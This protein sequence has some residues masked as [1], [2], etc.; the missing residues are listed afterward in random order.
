MSYDI[1][2][3]APGVTCPSCGRPADE[4]D[5][6]KPTYNLS[7]IFAKA[8]T[9]E[10]CVALRGTRARATGLHL[11]VGHAAKDTL[12]ALREAAAALD[13]PCRRILFR[14]LQPANGWGTVEDARRVIARLIIVAVDYPD[15]VWSVQ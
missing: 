14:N 5:C 2:L 10:A 7:P 4:P 8:F 3:H 11:L 1:Y 13:D 6:P 9:G 15:H 12:G